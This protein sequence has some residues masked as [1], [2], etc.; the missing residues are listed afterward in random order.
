MDVCLM[1]GALGISLHLVYY[2][3]FPAASEPA[4]HSVFLLYGSMPLI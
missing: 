3:I 4:F 2:E 1:F